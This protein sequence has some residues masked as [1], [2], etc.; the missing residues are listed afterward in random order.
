MVVTVRK[1]TTRLFS[2]VA[3]VLQMSNGYHDMFSEL[4]NKGGQSDCND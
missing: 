3:A 2:S 4:N 1:M